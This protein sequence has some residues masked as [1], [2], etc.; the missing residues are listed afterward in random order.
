MARER[1]AVPAT[2]ISVTP[3]RSKRQRHEEP[4]A[5][6]ARMKSTPVKLPSADDGVTAAAAAPVAPAESAPASVEAGLDRETLVQ[7][8][9]ALL[10]HR[11]ARAGGGAAGAN[12]DDADALAAD[13]DT[14][15]VVISLKRAPK[16]TT[17]KPRTVPLVHP[18]FTAGEDDVCFVVKDPQ[19]LVKDHLA[20]RG[21]QAVTKVLGV[22]KLEKRYGTHEA[23]RELAQQ[24]DLFLVDDRVVKM[25]PRLLGSTFIRGKKMPLVI[26]M[27]RDIPAGIARAMSST[28][29]T[30][31]SGTTCNLRVAKASF[32]AEQIADN[33]V[34]AME[35]IAAVLPGNWS[36]V[37]ALYV[38]TMSS[39]SLP[40]FVAL[41]EAKD[42]EPTSEEAAAK[43][44]ADRKKR[45]L[46]RAKAAREA[47]E[48]EAELE[49]QARKAEKKAERRAEKEDLKG[50]KAAKA[51]K[52]PGA[53]KAAKV[54]K[55]PGANKAA[56]TA[57]E[58]SGG[59]SDEDSDGIDE[60]ILASF[61]AGEADF[62]GAAVE[63][64]GWG[65]GEDGDS[66]GEGGA[67][68]EAEAIVLPAKR[69]RG[70]DTSS[71]PLVRAAKQTDGAPASDDGK[72]KKKARTTS[73]GEER[74]NKSKRPGGKG[75]KR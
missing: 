25:M 64:D 7:A 13:E 38:K 10:V 42:F 30:P 18:L 65:D 28:S 53:N 60:A 57:S 6:K 9:R 8:A 29:F 16:R 47:K 43:R 49:R 54:G 23:K 62:G 12:A 27:D 52:R 74:A 73:G 39:P 51:G 32:T 1:Q 21:V 44:S 2:P 14:V 56:V 5:E 71:R 11:A 61:E 75:A 17:L 24:Y 19:R 59:E 41:P 55:R 63:D 58:G 15:S 4:S 72:A 70:K 48:V 33:V 67:E 45:K 22:T 34:L 3:R 68:A 36:A 37:Q 46:A 26:R 66:G 69:K 35:S 31:S 20:E 50:P 40:V